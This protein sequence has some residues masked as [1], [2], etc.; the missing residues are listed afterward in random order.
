MP[1]LWKVSH[2]DRMVICVS[3]DVVTLEDFRGY[4]AALKKERALSFPKIFVATHGQ[5]GLGPGDRQKLAALLTSFLEID[6][7]GPFAVVA[8]SQRNDELA[9]VFMSLAAVRR[10]MRVF[11]DIHAARKWLDSRPAG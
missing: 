4:L 1:L 8:G 9:A 3:E 7:L 11:P 2:L 5:S 6:G 10:P